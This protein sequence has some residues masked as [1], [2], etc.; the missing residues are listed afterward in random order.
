MKKIA[1][2][3][4]MTIAMPTLDKNSVS[5]VWLSLHIVGIK[6]TAH[7]F[8]FVSFS[9]VDVRNSDCSNGTD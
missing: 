2:K 4:Q 1:K 9:Q 7:Y 3:E 6:F 8:I 5:G